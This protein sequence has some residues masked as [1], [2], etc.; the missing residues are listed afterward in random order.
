LLGAQKEIKFGRVS[1]GAAA[2]SD[3][4]LKLSVKVIMIVARIFEP[5]CQADNVPIFEGLQGLGKS[6]G[7]RELA[8]PWFTDRIS[9][10]GTK[11]SAI[12]AAG[13]WIMEI[14]E[15]DALTRA[16]NSAIKGFVSRSAKLIPITKLPRADYAR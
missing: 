16:T 1:P 11:D 14:S 4:A 9:K 15:L 7:I 2:L 6:S 10:L 13:A 8:H 3:E 5:G 12:E